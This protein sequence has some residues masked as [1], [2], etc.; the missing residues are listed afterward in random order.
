MRFIESEDYSY[1][2][3]A[4]KEYLQ[5]L[6]NHRGTSFHEVFPELNEMFKVKGG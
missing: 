4:L 1:R 5:L 2:L 3:P 6:D